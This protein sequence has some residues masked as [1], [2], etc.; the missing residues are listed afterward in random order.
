MSV[1]VLTQIAKAK[2]TGNYFGNGVDG[3]GILSGSVN[4]TS[5]TDGPAIIKNYTSLD[6]QSGATVTVS[7]RCKGLVIYVKGDC[8]IDGTLTMTARGPSA[9][10][11]SD[12]DFYRY[13]KG[14]LEDSTGLSANTDILTQETTS[15]QRLGKKYTK[16]GTLSVG[17][18]GG[19]HPSPNAP[20][21]GSMQTGGGGG[22]PRVYGGPVPNGGESYG[23]S[24]TAFGG[25]SGGGG[26]SPGGGPPG[27][28]AVGNPGTPNGGAGGTGVGGGP[29]GGTGGGGAGN[30]GGSGGSGGSNGTG[31]IIFLIVKGNLTIGASGTISSNGSAGG[32]GVPSGHPGGGGSGAGCINVLYAGSYTNNGTIQAN[33]G[34]GGSG[35]PTGGAGGA[36]SIIVA[37]IAR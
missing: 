28:Y 24:G 4:F 8:T 21:A 22:A 14:S 3:A 34:S 2:G 15:N 26:G 16:Y 5:S 11:P 10:T 37:K 1:F 29:S 9:A 33:G 20:A 35:T 32:N 7:N 12:I 27:A 17:G 36:G 18:P 25:G 19:Y 6:I 13:T 31:G 23:T 30:P